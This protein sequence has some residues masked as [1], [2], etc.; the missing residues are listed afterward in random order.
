MFISA[1]TSE[2]S[3]TVTIFKSDDY[4]NITHVEPVPPS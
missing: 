2:P 4:F 1:V 3:E